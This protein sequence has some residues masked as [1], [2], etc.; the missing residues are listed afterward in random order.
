MSTPLAMTERY[1]RIELHCMVCQHLNGLRKTLVVSFFPA[2]VFDLHWRAQSQQT[3]A[4]LLLVGIVLLVI[5]GIV[6]KVYFG[7]AE[8]RSHTMLHGKAG[9]IQEY[10]TSC[11]WHYMHGF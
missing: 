3:N 2:N 5:A 9:P 7:G 11:P 1:C 8:C 4:A 6:L 10:F